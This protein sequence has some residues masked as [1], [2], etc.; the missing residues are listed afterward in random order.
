V[1]GY[2]GSEPYLVFIRSTVY[3][4]GSNNNGHLDPGES[5][6]LTSTLVNIGGTDIINLNTT[7]QSSD[8][9]IS[10]TDN[11]GYFGALPVDS[12]KENTVDPYTL[13]ADASAPHGHNAEFM[14][15]ATGDGGFI[16]TT[17]FN[18][19]IGQDVPTDT[20]YYYAYYSGGP[21]LHCP[22]FDWL[23]IDTSQSQYAGTSLDLID[24]QNAIVNLP[25]NFTYYGVDYNRIS[26]GSN[27]FVAMDSTNDVDWSNTGIPSTD[28]PPTMI[29]AFWSDLDPGNSGAPSDIYW[30]Y[31]QPN[32]R[33]II[34][35]F[36]VE[37][38]PSGS[39]ETFEVI[40]YDP[41]YYPTPT[42]DGEILIQYLVPPQSNLAT[43]GIENSTETVGIEYYYNDNYNQWAVPVTS[44]FAIKYTTHTPAP[45][46]NEFDEP[47]QVSQLQLEV[48]PNP[49]NSH[50]KIRYSIP[51]TKP[52][53]RNPAISI[54]D[55]AGRL[56]KSFSLESSI[57]YPASEIVWDGTDQAN[58]KVPEG[59]Y[60][61]HLETY[62]GQ[63]TTKII[64]VR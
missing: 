1:L 45:G 5:A 21:H 3:D 26:V 56:V 22:T 57:E 59:V 54:Y 17:Y 12:V 18:L 62:A 61:V 39:N 41:A 6:D 50:T 36:Q 47:T 11:T 27:G 28:G 38:W 14:L 19:C 58:R 60:F 53:I 48:S 64:V 23:A 34:E 32:N 63:I 52:L 8:P 9:Y 30:Y 40:L 35:Y 42:G 29:A 51:D 20:G 33:F 2:T 37:H 4:G 25:F 10:V 24:N 16:D 49:C 46:I 13:S 31:D 55:A 44:N 15:V 7:I 43:I